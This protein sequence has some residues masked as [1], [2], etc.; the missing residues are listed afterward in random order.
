MRRC[1]LEQERR[2]S[3]PPR[4]AGAPTR[5]R[6]RLARH[7]RDSGAKKDRPS[8]PDSWRAASSMVGCSCSSRRQPARGGGGQTTHA[9]RSQ[10]THAAAGLH[11][12]LACA[13]TAVTRATA[14][15]EGAALAAPASSLCSTS[16]SEAA[17]GSKQ[18]CTPPATARRT[19][20]AAA[21]AAAS[22][23]AAL[24]PGAAGAA[25]CAACDVR[26]ACCCKQRMRPLS[27]SLLTRRSRR[28]TCRAA[29]GLHARCALV[30]GGGG[31]LANRGAPGWHGTSFASG[32]PPL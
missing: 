21:A 28:C 26:A 13:H 31:G 20:L 22:L 27:C 23:V 8:C 25:S 2:V 29:G 17:W 14:V 24:P 4:Q 7:V 10:G 19:R 16:T 5:R 18:L 9:T 12:S 11:Q 15:G 1:C 3:A 30:R 32:A 6:A